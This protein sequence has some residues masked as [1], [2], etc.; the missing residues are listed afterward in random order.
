MLTDYAGRIEERHQHSLA[1]RES[2]AIKSLNPEPVEEYYNKLVSEKRMTAEERSLRLE[3]LGEKIKAEEKRQK[4]KLHADSQQAMS[5]YAQANPETVR[6]WSVEDMKDQFPNAKNTDLTWIRGVADDALSRRTEDIYSKTL[7]QMTDEQAIGT[8]LESI[9]T[10]IRQMEFVNLSPAR[11]TRLKENMW[12]AMQTRYRTGL[13]AK[14]GTVSPLE[15]TQNPALFHQT[16]VDIDRGKITTLDQILERMYQDGVINFSNPDYQKLFS[17]I[18]KEKSE[19]LKGDY[20]SEKLKTIDL[21]YLDEDGNIPEELQPEWATMKAGVERIMESVLTKEPDNFVKADKQVKDFVDEMKTNRAKGWIEQ[22]KEG[23]KWGLVPWHAQGGLGAAIKRG[24]F[25][26]L[27]SGTPIG[28]IEQI[29]WLA[30]L[31]IET[32]PKKEKQSIMDVEPETI[33]DHIAIVNRLSQVN[34]ELA[35]EYDKKWRS[36]WQ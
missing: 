9:Q 8:P 30:K 20:A 28:R 16:M 17:R 15:E 26:G 3:V 10:S 13:Y 4:S 12:S 1:Y 7:G 11:A 24:V 22:T 25:R 21:M 34:E 18:P 5:A 19:I 29:S 23:L 31:G 27:I 36:K 33:G 14:P 32:I 2:I 35:R 6:A